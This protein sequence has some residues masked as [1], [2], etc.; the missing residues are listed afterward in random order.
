MPKGVKKV[1]TEE[2]LGLE[3]D[4]EMPVNNLFKV[5]RDADNNISVVPQLVFIDG[6]TIISQDLSEQE[7]LDLAGKMSR[8]K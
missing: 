1:V 7:A 8:F 2:V 6:S 5:I 3:Q 4:N